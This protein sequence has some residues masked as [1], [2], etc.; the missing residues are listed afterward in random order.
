MSTFAAVPLP[1]A[2]L[3]GAEPD[4][5]PVE[6]LL[7]LVLQHGGSDL[8]LT[9]GAPPVVRING[10]LRRLAGYPVLTGAVLRKTIYSILTQRQRDR[11]EENLELDLAY[12]L[13]GEARFRVNVFQQ[14]DALGAAFRLI[15]VTIKGI[16]QLGLPERVADFARQ[17]RGLVLVT[18][19]TG[20]GKSTTLAAMIDLINSTTA[21]HIVTIEDPIEF[22]HEGKM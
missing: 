17:P 14:R 13:P 20:S 19:P 15:P 11:F 9:A 22:V 3:T 1:E 4:L 7:R 10:R 6:P 2:P 12:S 8:H 21:K 16:R 18:G 5:L